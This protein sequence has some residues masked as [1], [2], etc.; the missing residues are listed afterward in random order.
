MTVDSVGYTADPHI[1]LYLTL[2]YKFDAGHVSLYENV[3]CL[4]IHVGYTSP[5]NQ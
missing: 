4:R 3:G 5:R 2:L 1:S